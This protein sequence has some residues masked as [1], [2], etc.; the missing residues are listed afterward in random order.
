MHNQSHTNRTPNSLLG[1]FLKGHSQHL[2]PH[3]LMSLLMFA[4]TRWRWR[5]FK[6]RLTSWFVKR[7]EVDVS[8]AAEPDVNAYPHFNA[9]FTRALR[10]GA[11]PL[12]DDPNAVVCPADGRISQAGDI[13]GGRILQAKGHHFS[14]SELLG[15]DSHDAR[16]FDDGKFMTVYLSPRD[17]HRVHMPISAQLCKMTHVPGRLFSVNPLTTRVIPRVFARNERVV[18]CFSTK[19]GPMAVVL[20]GAIFVGSMETVWHGRVTPPYRRRVTTWRY[21]SDELM[22]ARGDELGRFN[23]GSTVILLLP[24]GIFEWSSGL[25]AGSA[26]Q[27]MQAVANPR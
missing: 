17:Y 27:A 2:Y 5:A 4:L 22:Y 23:M 25:Q 8:L 12:P 9:F 11:R 14:V 18:A 19:W 15:G 26:V 16:L 3:H 10:P 20:V 13:N 1:D 21:E 24:P 7:Y 6:S